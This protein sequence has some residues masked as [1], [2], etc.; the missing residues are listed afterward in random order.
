MATVMEPNSDDYKA[1]VQ[2]MAD[3]PADE[4]TSEDLD[5][6]ER[7]MKEHEAA[8]AERLSYMASEEF[9]AEM[10]LKHDIYSRS[11]VDVEGPLTQFVREGGYGE[12]GGP[13]WGVEE[14]LL[15]GAYVSEYAR[16]DDG[17]KTVS[18]FVH[19]TSLLN[20]NRK[21]GSYLPLVDRGTME[22]YMSHV[23]LYG[24]EYG[25]YQP[26]T[27]KQF[28]PLYDM[29]YLSPE[30]FQDAEAYSVNLFKGRRED[31][32][33][34]E[35]STLEC[36]GLNMSQGKYVAEGYVS[37]CEADIRDR[38]NHGDSYDEIFPHLYTAEYGLS[39]PNDSCVQYDVPVR[40][41]L[42]SEE[43]MN[44]IR[45]LGYDDFVDKQRCSGYGMLDSEDKRVDWAHD[46][47]AEIKERAEYQEKLAKAGKGDV[48]D[49][50]AYP[51]I[52]DEKRVLYTQMKAVDMLEEGGIDV[53]NP[54][55]DWHNAMEAAR[56]VMKDESLHLFDEY[57]KKYAPADYAERN[58]T[59]KVLSGKV[60][61]MSEEE[62]KHRLE[63]RK[64]ERDSRIENATRLW[65]EHQGKDDDR[66]VDISG[67]KDVSSDN[68]DKGFDMDV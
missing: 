61:P 1:Y 57:D 20:E 36:R 65:K 24:N 21:E 25:L 42:L 34:P 35:V 18:D 7:E 33:S 26:F 30:R 6:M 15:M 45:G 60:A 28:S 12:V 50:K 10:A 67:L 22:L 31:A 56:C 4:P 16:M 40:Y 5:D 9:F 47:I 66:K 11:G 2:D 19:A 3:M 55:M 38:I 51:A 46:R 59:Q 63:Q 41:D 53:S 17:F 14:Q 52:L 23:S 8:R 58:Y 48:D 29:K 37:R 68:V 54:N 32:L 43:A 64:E 62:W 39:V 49:F 13:A 27:D 44:R